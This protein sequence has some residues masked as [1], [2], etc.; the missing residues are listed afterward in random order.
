M[1]PGG[2]R[3]SSTPSTAPALAKLRAHLRSDDRY[4]L[5]LLTLYGLRRSEVLGLCWDDVDLAAGTLT[6]A[7]GITETYGRRNEAR[8]PKTPRSARTLP[9][10]VDVLAALRELREVQMAA[11]GFEQVRT[12]WLAIDEAGQPLH[13]ERWTDPWRAHCRAA[14]VPM[15]T[16]H[17]A[18]HS[19]VTAMRRAG[20]PDRD[21]AAWHGHD[22]TTMR[23]IYDHVALDTLS[24]AGAVLP[25]V[26][27]STAVSNP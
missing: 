12:G 5:W 4:A 2:P 27:A 8:P 20:V 10:P 1:P 13:L 6:V 11:H 15:I 23:A 21:V 9:L 3:R 19:S 22:E 7:R 16:L 24:A 25:D 14:G 17:A 26:L 18:R